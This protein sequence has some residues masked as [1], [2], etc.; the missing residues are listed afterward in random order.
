MREEPCEPGIPGYYFGQL[1]RLPGYEA[2]GPRKE[3]VI[4]KA[5]IEEEKTLRGR[6]K[7]GH[8]E[9]VLSGYPSGLQYLRLSLEELEAIFEAWA[10]TRLTVG[11]KGV[12]EI[13]KARRAG[14]EQLILEG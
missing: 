8:Y 4:L 2:L 10:V 6:V 12:R 9:I 3:R 1:S 5:D 13:V 11:D 7:S 14:A